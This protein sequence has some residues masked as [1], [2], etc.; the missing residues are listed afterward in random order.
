MSSK[1]RYAGTQVRRYTGTQVYRYAGTETQVQ[2]HRYAGTH[3][4]SNLR[5][6]LHLKQNDT[7]NLYTCI[8]DIINL[9]QI[10][11]PIVDC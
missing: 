4:C 1:R 11:K 7:I 3:I 9:K 8:C 5:I 2:V 6:H 10:S